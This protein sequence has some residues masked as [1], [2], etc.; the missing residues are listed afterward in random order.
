[1]YV[2][3]PC[4]LVHWARPSSCLLCRQVIIQVL[5]YQFSAKIFDKNNE[6]SRRRKEDDLACVAQEK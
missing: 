5:K 1:M 6:K 3:H 4:F 2:Q